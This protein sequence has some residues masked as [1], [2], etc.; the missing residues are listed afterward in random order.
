MSIRSFWAASLIA[1]SAVPL[2]AGGPTTP[3]ATLKPQAFRQPLIF[4][5]N[6]GQA[7][8]QVQWIARA[9]QYQLFFTDEGLTMLLRDR[10]HEGPSSS[11]IPALFQAPRAVDRIKSTY[12]TIQIKLVGGRPWRIAAGLDPTGGISNYFIGDD[13]KAWHTGIQHYGRLSAPNVYDGIDMVFYS[14]GGEL[15]YDFLVAP[16][17]D[18]KQ[19]RLAF[20]GLDRT[21][22]DTNSGDLLLTAAGGAEVRQVRPKVYE[23]AGK[24]KTEIAA[25]YELLDRKQAA[26]TLAPYD[27]RHKL[28]IDPTVSFTTFLAGNGEDMAYAIAVD[29]S[30]NSYVTGETNSTNF[31][32][33]AGIQGDQPGQDAFVTKLSPSGAILFSNYWGG[34]GADGGTGIA[35]DTTGVFVT[36]T[37]NSTNFPGV[38]YAPNNGHYHAFV[39][40]FSLGANGIYST[41]VGGSGYDYSNAIALDTAHAAYITGYT[42][43]ADFPSVG[44]W[45]TTYGGSNDAFVVKVVPGGSVGASAYLGG[46]GDD[47]AWGIAVDQSGYAWIAGLTCSP[48]F[49]HTGPITIVPGCNTFVTRLSNTFSGIFFSTEFE[50]GTAAAI[51]VDPN[52]NAYVAG[53]TYYAS[54]ATTP[55]TFQPIKPSPYNSYSA[56]VTKLDP[57]GGIMYST[58]LSGA[59]G[60]TFA[61]A[62]AVDAGAGGQVYVAGWTSSTTFP[63]A[64]AITPNPAAGFLSKLTPQ[65]N[66]LEYT[67]FLGAGINGIALTG[68]SLYPQI[69]T[70][71]YRYTGGLTSSYLDAFVVELNETPIVT[72]K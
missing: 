58:Y 51:A 1:L 33:N 12:S 3:G 71:G 7:P 6:R 56:F 67:T 44:S 9:A 49:P 50:G 34:N 20:E 41:I 65:L 45:H 23:Q 42:S 60:N 15:E 39:T 36:G 64:P 61:K 40:K 31:P 25:A 19:I 30:G 21:R 29:S 62:I 54:V 28:V 48:N 72:R 57:L 55:G 8:A 46:T 13:P 26:F 18:P 70:A 47:T 68:L 4:E 22:I 59:N 17:A 32:T 11:L 37:T 16:G 14:H 66:A 43:S 5:P 52:Y 10:A 2:L 27:H 24:R 63:G 35:V 38:W 69:Y 53:N